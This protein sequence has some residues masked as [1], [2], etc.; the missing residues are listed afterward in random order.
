MN[1]GLAVVFGATGLANLLIVLIVGLIFAA[2][3]YWILSMFVPHPIPA[4][5]AAL[6]VLVAL[7]YALQG[8]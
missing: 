1:V 3:V 7:V 6:I 2:I 5:I 4:A 8:L